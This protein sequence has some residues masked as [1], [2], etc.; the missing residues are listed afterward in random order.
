MES[1]IAGVF[2]THDAA[3]AAHADVE[4]Q[5]SAGAF[6]VRSATVYERNA[7][8]DLDVADVETALPPSLDISNLPGGAGDEALAELDAKLPGS[9]HVLLVHADDSALA[10]IEA[11][12]AAHTG[13]IV[14]RTQSELQSNAFGRFID[15][16]SM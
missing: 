1:F 16:S 13:S 3:I 2:A 9:D 5:V 14:R 6:A 8:G 10:A 11:I 15:S 4:R 7:A 12:V